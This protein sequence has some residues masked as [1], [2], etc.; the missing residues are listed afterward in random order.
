MTCKRGQSPR[1]LLPFRSSNNGK[2]PANAPLCPGRGGAGVYIDWCVR[3]ISFVLPFFL[4]KQNS[5]HPWRKFSRTGERLEPRD[6]TLSEPVP[7]LMKTVLDRRFTIHMVG[8]TSAKQNSGTFQGL[9]E[10]KS[11]FSRNKIY[12]INQHSLTP[13]QTPYWL[14]HPMELF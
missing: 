10:N 1:Y 12:A 8:T 7:R 4:F 5:V 11:W 14:K 2:F 9:F 13:F 6:A 3:I